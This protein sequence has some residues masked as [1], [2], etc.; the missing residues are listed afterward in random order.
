MIVLL[1]KQVNTI[2]PAMALISKVFTSTYLYQIGLLPVKKNHR[3]TEMPGYCDFNQIEIGRDG[4]RM[5]L[6]CCSDGPYT[7]EDIES[8]AV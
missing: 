3:M 5:L 4:G 1:H 7:I 6:L 8:V 2:R